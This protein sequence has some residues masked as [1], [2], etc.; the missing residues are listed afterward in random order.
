MPYK[1]FINRLPSLLFNQEIASFLCVRGRAVI[2][3][4][5]LNRKGRVLSNDDFINGIKLYTGCEIQELEL[6]DGRH[7]PVDDVVQFP[8]EQSLQL[9]KTIER[10]P[11]ILKV[12][13]RIGELLP[14]EITLTNGVVGPTTFTDLEDTLCKHE[15]DQYHPVHSLEANCTDGVKLLDIFFNDT[16][17][18]T[19][20]CV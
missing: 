12:R 10:F 15:F 2:L 14:L 5:S 8:S 16:N 4:K 6:T 7:T 11:R 18:E 20:G 13:H 3:L 17:K 9:L 1:Y 19:T